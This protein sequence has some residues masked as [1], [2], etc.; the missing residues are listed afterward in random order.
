M[1]YI[2]VIY[3]Y[4]SA[5]DNGSIVILLILFN[6]IKLPVAVWTAI[7]IGSLGG[8]INSP[9]RSLLSNLVTEDE[10]VELFSLLCIGETTAKFFAFILTALYGATLNI[11]PGM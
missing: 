7:T 6:V 5:A 2:L 1:A 10:A 4:L 8:V 3:G 9:A 11:F